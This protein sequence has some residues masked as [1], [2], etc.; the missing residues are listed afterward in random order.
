MF[1]TKGISWVR[2]WEGLFEDTG[3][4]IA[5]NYIIIIYEQHII[6][7]NSSYIAPTFT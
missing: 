3:E 2:R 4:D 5:Y 6:E 7:S 1:L